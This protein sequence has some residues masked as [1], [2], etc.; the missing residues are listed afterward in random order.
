M[1]LGDTQTVLWIPTKEIANLF[2]AE[3]LKFTL[4]MERIGPIDNYIF[5][6]IQYELDNDISG[7]AKDLQDD[8]FSP[9]RLSEE[10]LKIME[11]TDYAF[12]KIFQEIQ[13]K[14]QVRFEAE[15]RIQYGVTDVDIYN[16]T[17]DQRE[18]QNFFYNPEKIKWVVNANEINKIKELN[19]IIVTYE[20]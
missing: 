2:P 1:S 15:I 4:E 13:S 7:L 9:F 10:T 11:E 19:P 14:F 17:G 16:N 6:W 18:L 3:Y 5:D 12:Y 8:S 20:Y